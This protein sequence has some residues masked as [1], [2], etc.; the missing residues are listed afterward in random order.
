MNEER[1]LHYLAHWSVSNRSSALLEATIDNL[2]SLN[3]PGVDSTHVL[4]KAES[5]SK[6]ERRSLI[7]E[8]YEIILLIGDNLGDFDGIFD[9]RS[10]DFGKTTVRQMEKEFGTRFIIFPN[11][12][13]GSWE[14]GVFPD[15]MPEERKI[16]EKLRGY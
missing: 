14:R 8:N 10:T 6:D 2:R 13:Y 1:Q 5:S 3:F 7:R 16:L 11:P 12:M 15:G 4:L 9:D